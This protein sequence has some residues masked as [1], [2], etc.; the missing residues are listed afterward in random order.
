MFFSTEK[1]AF[2]SMVNLQGL[3]GLQ[4]MNNISKILVPDAFRGKHRKL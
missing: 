4:E 3:E 2:I 1:A